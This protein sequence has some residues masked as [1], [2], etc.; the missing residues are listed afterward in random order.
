[1]LNP[2]CHADIISAFFLKKVNC[3]LYNY[4][5]MLSAESPCQIYSIIQD[6]LKRDTQQ[7]RETLHLLQ[8]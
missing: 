2:I 4:A 6:L 1:M 3:R 5:D 8:I 7:E